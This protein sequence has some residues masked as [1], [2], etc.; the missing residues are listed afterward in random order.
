MLIVT[1][2]TD[3]IL[4]EKNL[5]HYKLSKLI[6]KNESYINHIF[7]GEQPFSKNVIKKLLPILE[8]SKEEFQGWILSDKYSSEVLKLA[9][10]TKKGFQFKRKSILTVKIDMLLQER[11]MSRTAL[12]KQITYSQSGLNRMI[13]GKINMSGFVLEKIS[14]IL[15]ISQNEILSWVLADKYTLQTLETAYS[16][17]NLAS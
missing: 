10:E 14:N 2:K 6:K 12:A 16:C 1:K 15:D 8:V 5:S 17:K 9:I 4:K 3:E 7:R 13:T 11:N